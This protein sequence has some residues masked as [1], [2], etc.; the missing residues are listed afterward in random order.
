MAKKL[1]KE[2]F[3]TFPAE[4]GQLED[5]RGSIDNVLADSTLGQKDKNSVLLARPDQRR[6]ST[7]Q[8]APRATSC[9]AT[10]YYPEKEN[11]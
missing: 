10:L 6:Y 8:P 11:G 5:I 4:E 2:V 9:W 7:L 1:V 3:L